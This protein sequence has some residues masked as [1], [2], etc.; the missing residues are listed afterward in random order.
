MYFRGGLV[1]SGMGALEVG[2]LG[3]QLTPHITKQ[4]RDWS[5]RAVEK[6]INACRVCFQTSVSYTHLTLPTIYSV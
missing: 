2:H 6:K 3:K 4:L 5:L 1:S